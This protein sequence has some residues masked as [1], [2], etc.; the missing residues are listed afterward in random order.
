MGKIQDITKT[1]LEAFVEHL[2]D[3][4]INISTVKLRLAQL[5]AFLRFLIDTGAIRED[6]FPWNLTIK[7]PEPLPRAMD[8]EDVG[9]TERP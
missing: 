2:Q 6:V 1:D 4:G 9:T 5:K 3:K 7:M 8:P